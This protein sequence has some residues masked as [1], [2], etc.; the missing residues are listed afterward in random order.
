MIR[1]ANS[2]L[3]KLTIHTQLFFLTVLYHGVYVGAKEVVLYYLY[4]V[5]YPGVTKCMHHNGFLI[6]DSV[7]NVYIQGTLLPQVEVGVAQMSIYVQLTNTYLA[8]LIDN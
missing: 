8:R 7:K 6:V 1:W 4:P 5:F 2:F 3:K